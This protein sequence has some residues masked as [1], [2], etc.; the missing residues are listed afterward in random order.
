M[1]RMAQWLEQQY[2]EAIVTG[3]NPRVNLY[4][5]N[6]ILRFGCLRIVFFSTPVKMINFHQF[7]VDA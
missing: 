3:S 4:F 1:V 7:S 5:F 6:L 2:S